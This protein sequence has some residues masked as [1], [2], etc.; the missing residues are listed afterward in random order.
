MALIIW[1]ESLSVHVKKIDEQHQ[2]LIQLINDLH[3]AMRQR[4]TN[5]A[6]GKIIDELIAYTTSHFLTEETYFEQFQYIDRL[7]HKRRHSEFV[8]K[9]GEFQKE[10]T[11]GK[12]MLS[13]E[14][15]TFL[16]DWLVNHIQ[17]EDK[18]YVPLFKEKGLQ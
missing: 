7:A 18:K 1:D 5:E 2:K 17:G 6:L 4:K 14:I 9:V 8:K 3:E 13:M 16:K 11:S 15:M 10:F 12:L